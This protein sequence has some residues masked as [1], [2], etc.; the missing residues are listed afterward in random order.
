MSAQPKISRMSQLYSR[1]RSV[2]RRL[3]DLESRLASRV[4]A[5]RR[6]A[7]NLVE[8]T[9]TSRRSHMRI[10]VSHRVEGGEDVDA[11]EGKGEKKADVGADA[12]SSSAAAAPAPATGRP[13]GGKDFSAL[14]HSSAHQN[15]ENNSASSSGEAKRPLPARQSQPRKGVRRWMLVVEGGLLIKHLDHESAKEVDARLDAGLSILGRDSGVEDER[16]GKAVM[17][18]KSTHRIPQ[19]DQWRGG[20]SERENERDIEPLKFTH[21]FDRLEVELRAYKKTDKSSEPLEPAVTRSGLGAVAEAP[22]PALPA[23]VKMFTWERSKSDAPD[24]HAFFVAYDEESEFKP[25]GGKVFKSEFNLDRVAA[26]IKLFRRR[27]EEEAYVPSAQLCGVFFPTFIGK[28]A[29]GEVKYKEKS[30]SKSKKRKRLG[31]GSGGGGSD[32]LSNSPSSS[33]LEHHDASNSSLGS[34]PLG[35][36]SAFA[37]RQAQSGVASP[38]GGAAAAASVASGEEKDVHVPN[39]VTMDEAL[40]AIF[41]YIRSRNLQDATDLSIINNDERLSILFGCGRML[42]SA[43]RGLLLEK[44]LLVKVEQCT[45]PIMFNYVMTLD[46]A[47]PLTKKSLAKKAF[48]SGEAETMARTRSDNIQ[49]DPEPREDIPH[50]TMLSCD[51]DIEVPNLFHVRTRD[52]L[53][54]TKYREFEYTSGRIKSLRSLAAAGVSEET[55]KLAMGDVVT[56]R[57]YAPHHRQAWMALAKGSHEGGEAQRAAWIDLRTAT[58]MERLEERCS[59]ARGWWDVANACRGLCDAKP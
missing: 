52:I 59:V 55:A 34:I 11:K 20:T 22:P 54:R 58:L 14:L 2:L 56:G 44:Q 27:G 16:D 24:S 9:P 19:R 30:S 33:H 28:K 4:A 35:K 5:H 36:E 43:V 18:E 25:M 50:Q 47:E 45:N 17:R 7:T 39:T 6:R 38:G 49:A 1:H 31:G 48:Q 42:F 15:A 21:L 13:S 53:R 23:D 29:A 37:S 8:E 32:N 12:A 40:H 41:F 46:G 10:F 57:G 51:V 26:K 3:D